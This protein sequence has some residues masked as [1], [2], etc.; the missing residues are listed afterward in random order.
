[1]PY[2]LQF[3]I[4]LLIANVVVFALS[5]WLSDLGFLVNLVFAVVA[6]YLAILVGR[7]VLRRDQL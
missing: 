1:M 2:W 4:L 3:I 5:H 7:R 6:G